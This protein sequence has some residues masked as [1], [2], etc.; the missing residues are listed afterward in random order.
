[1]YCMAITFC[2]HR[3]LFFNA[4]EGKLEP[5]LSSELSMTCNM[6]PLAVPDVVHIMYEYWTEIKAIFVE[7]DKKWDA[8]KA[9]VDLATQGDHPN[10]MFVYGLMVRTYP[11]HKAFIVK[12]FREKQAPMGQWGAW[13]RYGHCTREKKCGGFHKERTRQCLSSGGCI[14]LDQQ[15]Q[16]CPFDKGDG[17]C[18]RTS[19]DVG[20]QKPLAQKAQWY[21]EKVRCICTRSTHQYE[22]LEKACP[23]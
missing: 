14:G 12:I 3:R 17:Q 18:N 10:Y 5:I 2:F 20:Q 6:Q 21:A 13:S 8:I 11:A 15:K 4:V 1:M 22:G 19:N 23:T 9:A 16:A 7:L